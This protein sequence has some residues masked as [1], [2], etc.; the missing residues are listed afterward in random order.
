M[1]PVFRNILVVILVCMLVG[2]Y[3]PVGLRPEAHAANVQGL[4]QKKRTTQRELKRIKELKRQVIQKE[5]FVTYNIVQNQKLLEYSRSSLQAQ[6]ELLH[7]TK[8]ELR[9][10]QESLDIALAEQQELS[11]KVGKRL[12]SMYTGERL[13]FLHMLLNAGNLANLMD[14]T[15][16]KKRIF[17]QDKDLYEDYIRKTQLLAEKKD[18]LMREKNRLAET[19]NRIHSYQNQLQESVVLDRMLVNKLRTSRDAYEMAENQL[20][21]ESY[22]IAQQIFAATRRGGTILGSTG[23]F[24]AP[25]FAAMTSSFGYRFHPIFKTRRFHAGIDFGA[26]TGTPIRAADGGRIIQSGWQGG[27]GK[28]VIINHGAQKGRNLTTLYAH[29]SRT[30]VGIGQQVAK[31]QV[32]GYVGST[33]F[34]TGPHLHFEV[35]QDG[36]PINP[37][38]FLR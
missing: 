28:V 18:M 35:R 26:G 34:S 21:R 31:G 13:G 9:A 25:V 12:R 17:Q 20:E 27:Y 30:V 4:E 33:G 14:R 37:L 23:R 38:G 32:I 29:M 5:K 7:R 8:T 15:Y 24:M 2:V 6:T 1:A 22:T 16:Y 10:L 36:Q 11:A 3:G 19:I